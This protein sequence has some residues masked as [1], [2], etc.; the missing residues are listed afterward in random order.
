MGV[1]FT[2]THRR[3]RRFVA[4]RRLLLTL[5]DGPSTQRTLRT[6]SISLITLH[7]RLRTFVRRAAPILP[8]DRRRHSARPALDFRHMLRHTIFRIRS[9]NHGRIANT[10]ILITV[11]DRRRSRTTCLLHGRRIDHLSIIGFVSRNAHGSRPARSSSP[12]D[13]PGDR[14]RTNKRRHVRGFAAGLGRLTHINKVSP[15]VNH[16]GRLRHTVRILYHH[17][18]G[19]PLLI[20]RSNINGATVTRNLT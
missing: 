3:H 1:T 2:E 14:R 20:K 6:Y 8:T 15:L 10:G 17:H 7:R 4:I 18:G 12:N 11:F 16:R 19:G 5:L 13:R 9:S